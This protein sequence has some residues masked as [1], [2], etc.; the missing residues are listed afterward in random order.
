MSTQPQLPWHDPVWQKEAQDWIHAETEHR[1]IHITGEIEQPHSYPWS[2]VLR[3]LTNEGTLFFKATATETVYE[4]ALTKKLAEWFPDCIPDLVAV[5]TTRGWMV[6][7]AKN[8]QAS[9]L[10]S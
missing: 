3:V 5:D 10:S 1:S 9:C 4:S 7:C 8:T 2:T 6:P